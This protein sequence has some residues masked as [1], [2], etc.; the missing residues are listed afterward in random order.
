MPEEQTIAKVHEDERE[1][2][3]PSTQA[4]EFVREEVHHVREG[5]HGARSTRQMIA[6]G[7]SKARRA[8][9]KL[10]APKKTKTSSRTRRQAPRSAE[11]R[12]SKAQDLHETVAC[13]EICSESRRPSRGIIDGT[14]E[15]G[16]KRGEKAIQKLAEDGSEEGRA[17][18]KSASRLRKEFAIRHPADRFLHAVDAANTALR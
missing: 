11:G 4:G 13:G 9:V 2:K 3:S 6:I 1:G 17:N 14:I 8:G 18:S 7:L 12:R 16:T 10:P 15:A 5:K